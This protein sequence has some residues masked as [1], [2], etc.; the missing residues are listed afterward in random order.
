[1]RCQVIDELAFRSKGI[2]PN[3]FWKP[4]INYPATNT[5]HSANVLPLEKQI[6]SALRPAF[7]TLSAGVLLL[8]LI[9]C[10]NLANLL[11]A[12]ARGRMR[13][14][15]IRL[16]LG[17]SRGDIVRL[18]LAESLLLSAAGAIAGVILAQ[19]SLPII[20]SLLPQSSGVV[21]L[22]PVDA[23]TIDYRV[24]LFAT[25][26]ALLTG[27]LFGLFPAWTLFR[28]AA[29]SMLHQTTRSGPGDA[30]SIRARK[31]L[32]AIEVAVA[33]V[34]LTGAL[35]FVVSLLGLTRVNPGFQ[36]DRRLSMNI[37][38]GVNLYQ[39]SFA[40]SPS[41]IAWLRVYPRCQ[42]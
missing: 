34:L 19:M 29:D 7:T 20:R 26:L 17:A 9:A 32:A 28:G 2:H 38:L 41:A 15:R 8:L 21:L 35:L 22:P 39:R 25:G 40:R 36:A 16:A 37:A 10:A 5:G 31:A 11:L 4:L 30:R 14:I 3:S 1:L 18:L 27:L 42:G 12:R 23:L 24:L 13:E 6:R 33:C